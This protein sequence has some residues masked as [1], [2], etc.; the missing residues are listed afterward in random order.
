MKLFTGGK[1]GG[2][3][4]PLVQIIKEGNFDSLYVGYQDAL[5]EKI[6]LKNKVDFYGMK[7][8]ESKLGLISNYKELNKYMKNKEIE[9]VI[10]TG[11]I[12]SLPLCLYA[13]IHK[14]P[15]YL[16]EENWIR[17]FS[18]LV[19]YPFCK[20]MFLA[21]PLQKTWKKECV[22]G[23]PIKSYKPNVIKEYDVLIIGG[24][25]GSRPLCDIATRLSKK[26]KVC[27]ICGRYY[28]DY[29]GYD[30]DIYDFCD[31][32]YSLMLKSRVVLARG[33]S[34][35]AS[36]IIYLNIPFICI[37]S[38]NTK[39]NHQVINAKAFDRLGVCKYIDEDDYDKICENIN[40]FLNDNNKR[41]EMVVKQRMFSYGNSTLKIIEEIKNE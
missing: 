32:I 9:L 40:L 12:T 33:G 11:G 37:P 6:C 10:S 27:L 7:Q 5:E 41:L 21:Y 39:R 38:K 18:N 22:T 17:G 26:Y 15:L 3:I 8:Y 2:H 23:L 14:I 31:D 29:K 28:D 24:S 13:V 30:F 1:T 16:I 36:E 25:L 19:F 20:K 34:S 4:M 35:T